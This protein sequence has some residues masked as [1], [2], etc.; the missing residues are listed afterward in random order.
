MSPTSFQS[1]LKVQL[2]PLILQP[3]DNRLNV[4]FPSFRLRRRFN[5]F[6]KT[7]FP[8]ISEPRNDIIQKTMSLHRHINVARGSRDGDAFL[9]ADGAGHDITTPPQ[10]PV[11]L[12]DLPP[13]TAQSTEAGR[14]A[15]W[16]LVLAKLAGA[17]RP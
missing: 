8:T 11:G 9:Y 14:V 7:G 15:F 3:I 12:S 1:P 16:T 4:A 10:L 17:V 13:Q 6:M 5:N 2:S